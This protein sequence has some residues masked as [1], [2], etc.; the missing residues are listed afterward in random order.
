MFQPGCPAVTLRRDS[1][2]RFAHRL[3]K[4]QPGLPWP[5]RAGPGKPLCGNGLV[6]AGRQGFEPRQRGSEPQEVTWV[7]SGAVA[8]SLKRTA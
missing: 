5:E 3:Q 6:L 7:L 1:A 4:R 2:E 8:G